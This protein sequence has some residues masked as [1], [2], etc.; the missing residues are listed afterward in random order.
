M[1]WQVICALTDIATK[2]RLAP[3]AWRPRD[4]QLLMDRAADYTDEWF[5][6]GADS[7]AVSFRSFFL[8]GRVVDDTVC[9]TVTMASH[10]LRHYQEPLADG[11]C[12]YCPI[13][14]SRYEQSN[15]VLVEF[16][17]E[18]RPHFVLA[19]YP[20]VEFREVKWASVRR[21]HPHATT[22]EV[23]LAAIPAV[24]PS[25]GRDL[26]MP[27]F[28]HPG[29][30]SFRQGVFESAPRLEWSS[31]LPSRAT[32]RAILRGV[33]PSAPAAAAPA[34]RARN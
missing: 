15:G 24:A 34:P 25:A 8:C 7:T 22:P 3:T 2:A 27:I 32:R 16:L 23:L 21:R 11:Q 19:P 1:A 18:G 20:P 33:R 12:W 31:L 13:C 6:V 17:A 14:E 28:D 9:S 26:L 29:S 4:Q 10:W 30:W 5:W